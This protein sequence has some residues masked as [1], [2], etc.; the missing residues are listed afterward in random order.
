MG[1]GAED[2][3]GEDDA[4][5][6]GKRANNAWCLLFNSMLFSYRLLQTALVMLSS[7]WVAGERVRRSG[8]ESGGTHRVPDL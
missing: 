5:E 1:E 4:G 2:P 7:A 6:G 8:Y 3:A